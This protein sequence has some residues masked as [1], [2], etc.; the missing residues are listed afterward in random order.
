M[1]ERSPFGNFKKFVN[2]RT[3]R[4]RLEFNILCLVNTRYNL[5]TKLQKLLRAVVV[6]LQAQNC[7]VSLFLVGPMK[8]TFLITMPT[9]HIQSKRKHIVWFKMISRLYNMKK[10]SKHSRNREKTLV[11]DWSQ[12]PIGTTFPSKPHLI[13]LFSR[14]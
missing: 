1:S 11:S 5:I 14:F 7:P 12:C 8:N 4:M 10:S 3:E 2:F 6:C 13:T 9:L